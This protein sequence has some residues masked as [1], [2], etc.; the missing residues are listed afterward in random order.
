[1]KELA[2]GVDHVAVVVNGE[3]AVSGV[4]GLVRGQVRLQCKEA[5]TRY[6]QIQEF[7]EFTIFPWL[8]TWEISFRLTPC[9]TT[10]EFF[11]S[12]EV[13]KMS[14]NWARDFLNPMVPTL[15][16]LLLDTPS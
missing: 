10:L 1:M 4:D 13:A 5:L 6:R 9:P 8:K 12:G 3:A 15:A 11:C 7:A 2:N 16:M 14:P